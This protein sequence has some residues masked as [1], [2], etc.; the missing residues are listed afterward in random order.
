MKVCI[1]TYDE[2]IN[3]PYIEKYQRFFELN[4]ISYDIIL[5][6]R[7]NI[8]D[9]QEETN[10]YV[11]KSRV[12]K[13][14]LSKILPFLKWRRYTLKILKKYKYDRIVV[15]TTLPAILIKSYILKKY[16]EKYILDIRDYTY[17]NIC[18]Y[19]KM[20]DKIV[21][22]SL[23]TYISSKGFKSWLKPSEK[24]TLTHNITNAEMEFKKEHIN[25]NL[26]KITIG[27][28]GGI[29]YYHENCYLIN[30]MKEHLNVQLKYIGKVHEGIDLEGYCT[31]KSISNVEFQP[32]Y[33]NSDKPKI[34]QGIDFINAIYGNK[35]NTVRTALPNKLYDSIL[36]KVPIIV[37]KG[38]FLAE[39]V[40][41]YH[42]GFAI[43]IEKEDVYH[44][45]KQYIE[46]FNEKVFIDGCNALKNEVYKEEIIS[47]EKLKMII[48]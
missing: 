4:N 25:L 15:L 44:V 11:F 43:D 5:W 13:S 14:K 22:K 24:L 17:E 3:I 38:T 27:F 12:G 23:I 42:L 6:D 32:A 1:V 18:L 9:S 31:K 48:Y 29:R 28:V 30:N 46:N 45:L 10:Y 21:D 47:S 41:K 2:Y 26:D 36:Y 33:I 37:S 39:I 16:E 35:N 40:E 34:Y 7:R 8:I 19:R 20:V